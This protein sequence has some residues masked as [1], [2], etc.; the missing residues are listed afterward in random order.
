MALPL[1][2]F[3]RLSF[4]P[5][6]TRPHG[7]VGVTQTRPISTRLSNQK[8]A[9]AVAP[10]CCMRDGGRSLEVGLQELTSNRLTL[11]GVE[12]FRVVSG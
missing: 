11:L 5:R 10:R 6:L 8:C 9:S 3:L 2:S 12:R 1:L 7:L 4:T